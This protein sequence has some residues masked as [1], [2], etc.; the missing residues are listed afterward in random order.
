MLWWKYFISQVCNSSFPFL[1][2]FFI[3]SHTVAFSN[4]HFSFFLLAF[5]SSLLHIISH[6][7]PQSNTTSQLI[8]MTTSPSTI[9]FSLC[10]NCGDHYYFPF[11]V[12]SSP[13]YFC[14]WSTLPMLSIVTSSPCPTMISTIVLPSS[15]PFTTSSLMPQV[16]VNL[17][18]SPSSI[19]IVFYHHYYTLSE[20]LF[21]LPPSSIS[22]FCVAT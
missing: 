11:V 20:A 22:C 12:T 6:T 21:S 16:V 15:L 8:A 10:I 4:F 13:F 9:Q 1:I 19:S 18:L 17:E 7:P 2:S 5:S 14:T 3:F